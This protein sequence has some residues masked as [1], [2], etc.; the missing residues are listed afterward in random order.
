[1]VLTEPQSTATNL[2]PNRAIEAI[3]DYRPEP[4]SAST[5]SSKLSG[6]TNCCSRLTDH[7]TRGSFHNPHTYADHRGAWTGADPYL[8]GDIVRAAAASISV[9][10]AH[11]SAPTFDPM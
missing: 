3:E 6:S 1:M 11:I 5:R 8:L 4:P 10:L 7:T 2:K 9:Q